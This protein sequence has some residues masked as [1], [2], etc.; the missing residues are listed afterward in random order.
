MKGL[1]FAVRS[2]QSEGSAERPGPGVAGR[3]AGNEAAGGNP[4]EVIC[5]RD[6]RRRKAVL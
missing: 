6:Q 5:Q 2:D 3:M 4:E 1:T